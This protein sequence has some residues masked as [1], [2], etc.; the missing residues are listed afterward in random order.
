MTQEDL[1]EILS[2]SP[3]AISRWETDMAMPDISLIAPLCNL[4]NV[5]SD[6][7]LEI[8]QTQKQKSIDNICE[9]ADKYSTRGYLDE[10]RNILEKGLN[11]YPGNIDLIYHLMYLSFWQYGLAHENK[12]INEAIN[13]GEIILKRST[14]NYQRHGAIQILCYA[15]KNIGRIDE[16][17]KLAK[18]MPFIFAAPETL[19][20][21]IYSGSKAY[22]AKQ[23]EV[24]VLLQ[25]LSNSLFSL[26]T[27]MDSGEWAYTQEDYIFLLNKRIALLN[28][29]FENGD[30]GFFHNHL[31]STYCELA[32]H[33]AQKGDNVKALE[34]LRLSAEH[35]IKFITSV[36]EKCFS[37]VFRGIEI[38]SWV[39]DDSDNDASYLLKKM[40]NPA[41]EKIREK[42]EYVKIKDN[43]L[44]YARVWEI[45]D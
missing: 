18:S 24:Y 5:T 28:L 19:L 40:E 25:H 37:I 2:I 22:D 3:Q 38:G 23:R 21:R 9:E 1:A 17:I 13:L 43:L 20:S 32:I 26:Q 4:F 12:Y 14:E 45:N 42:E 10:A 35:S 7:L 39:T 16:A 30:F 27:K 44:K 8:D 33:Y 11:K 41:F 31:C 6:E 29:F 34:N 36:N 15:Y